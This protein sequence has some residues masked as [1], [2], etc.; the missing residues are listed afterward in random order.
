MWF[1]PL[2]FKRVPKIIFQ[3]APRV[4]AIVRRKRTAKI[5]FYSVF[6]MRMSGMRTPD[7]VSERKRSIGR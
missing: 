6:P 5:I 1:G 2:L 3:A 7:G 4:L